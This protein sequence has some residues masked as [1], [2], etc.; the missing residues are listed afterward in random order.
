MPLSG[1]AEVVVLAPLIALVWA[2]GAAWI[3]AWDYLETRRAR[4]RPGDKPD[5]RHVEA[6]HHAGA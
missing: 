3:K 1:A 4:V 5:S 6:A 2:A